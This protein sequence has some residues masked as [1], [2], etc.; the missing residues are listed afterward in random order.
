MNGQENLATRYTPRRTQELLIKWANLP[1][2][3]EG[4]ERHA[5][6]SLHSSFPEIFGELRDLGSKAV[7]EKY[8]F[9]SVWGIRDHL[10][11]VWNAPNVRDREWYIFRLRQLHYWHMN[12]LAAPTMK[13][14]F[15]RAAATLNEKL[16]ALHVAGES[17]EKFFER[18]RNDPEAQ[19]VLDKPLS[20]AEQRAAEARWNQR[21]SLYRQLEQSGVD[22]F[23]DGR[24][25]GYLI[26][27]PPAPR[28]F[29]QAMWFF[30]RIASHARYCQNPDCVAPY[31]ITNK[32]YKY[33]GRAE[34]KAYGQRKAKSKWWE[35]RG[36]QWRAARQRREI[37][38]AQSGRRKGGQR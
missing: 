32:N 31:F 24:F 7:K 25:W 11:A 3:Q 15:D 34:C 1:D 8:F 12:A 29:E 22:F 28:A 9:R 14:A 17:M 26:E 37:S 13:V 21:P 10:R 36:D 20:P 19:N 27:P 6:S 35:E 5:I 18:L 16:N 23:R 2:P 33:C 30:Q 4:K 38:R